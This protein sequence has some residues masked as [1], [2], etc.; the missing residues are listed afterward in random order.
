[1]QLDPWWNQAVEQQAFCRVFRKSPLQSPHNE[2]S[3]QLTKPLQGIGQTKNTSTTH[4]CIKNTIDA[5]IYAL[6]DSK[7][8]SIDA[9]LDDSKRKERITVRELM[10]LFGRLETHDGTETGIP[11]I[12]AYDSKGDD[13]EHDEDDGMRFS[14]PARAAGRESEDEG[15]GIVD[16]E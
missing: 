15:D 9:A 8:E 5:A 6:Q 11:Y 7:Q 10:S 4:L 16:E 2:I 3:T 14:P 13:D 1:L 12:F